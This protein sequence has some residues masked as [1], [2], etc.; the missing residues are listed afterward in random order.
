[1]A[2]TE[3]VVDG[4]IRLAG[5]PADA[6]PST[7]ALNLPALTVTPD[8]LLRAVAEHLPAGAELPV[9]WDHDPVIQAVI[10][11]WPKAFTS[12]SA[13]ALGF[14]ADE[15]AAALVAAHRRQVDL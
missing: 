8:E 4:F 3:K 12:A 11:G 2:S 7:R 15:S 5:I 6:L 13:L 10:D 14:T 1:M 9:D